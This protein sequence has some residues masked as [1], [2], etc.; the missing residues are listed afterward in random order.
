MAA[1]YIMTNYGPMSITGLKKV[2]DDHIKEILKDAPQDM[3][4]F[5]EVYEKY[6]ELVDNVKKIDLSTKQDILTSAQLAVINGNWQPVGNYLTEHQSLA[7]YA[8]KSEL[9]NDSEIR[10]LISAKQDKGD[11]ATEIWVE[12]KNYLTEH[13][14]ISGKQDVITDLETIR[15][16]AAKGSTALQSHQSLEAYATKTWVEDKNYLT[17]HQSLTEYAKKSEI[18]EEYNDTELRTLISNKQDTIADLETIRS[19]SNTAIQPSDIS[20]METRTHADNTYQVKGDY[21]TNEEVAAIKRSLEEVIYKNEVYGVSHKYT[22]ASPILERIGNL[23]NHKEL[24]VQSLMKRCLLTDSGEVTYLDPQDSTKLATGEDAILDGT[25]GQV[26]VEIPEHYRKFTLTEDSYN[27]EISLYPFVGAH[28]VNKCYISAYE[29]SLDRT[30]NKLSS[31]VNTTTQFRGGTN[32]SAWDDTYRSLLGRPVTG[33]SLTNFRTYANNRGSN[34]KCQEWDIY[35]AVYWLYTIEYAN[36]NCQSAFNEN[37]TDEGYKQGGLGSGVTNISNWN[38][39]NGY[40]PFVPCGYTN[41]LGNYTGII[42]YPT[43]N[44]DGTIR[45]NAP[46]PS[47]RGIE[48]PFGHIWK[49][50]DGVL[51]KGNGTIQEYYKTNNRSEYSSS[52]TSDYIKIGESPTGN[53]YKK[54]ILRNYQGDIMTSVVGGSDTTY[55]CDYHYQAVSNGT[56]YGFL[57]GGCANHGARAGFGSLDSYDGPAST[58]ADIGSRICYCEKSSIIE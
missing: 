44:E 11:Y 54:E 19:K 39:Y 9:Y 27:C 1:Y 40:N 36:L 32:Q 51:A 28:K 5:L 12:N 29:A 16:G 18:P 33:V 45:Y 41:S 37:T 52:L 25:A 10:S 47:Y 2:S 6:A 42:T 35:C 3:D 49:W 56:I 24:P 22:L 20:D 8:K 53:G 38:G 15:D 17:E 30:N 4:T 46:V 57:S 43:P 31:V 14:D 13:Q 48:N 58:S 7:E 26:M 21:S 50:T 55:F 23:N 34:W